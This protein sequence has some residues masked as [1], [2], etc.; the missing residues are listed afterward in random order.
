[1]AA[2]TAEGS[3]PARDGQVTWESYVWFGILAHNGENTIFMQ[4]LTTLNKNT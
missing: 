1:M 3:L 2:G 4:S